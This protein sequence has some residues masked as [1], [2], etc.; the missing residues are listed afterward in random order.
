MAEVH[1]IAD[2]IF[3]ISSYNEQAKLTFNQFLIRDERPLLFHTGQR[4]IFQDTLAA[5]RSLIDPAAL[6]YISWSHWEGDETGALNDFLAAEPGAEPVHGAL[7][8]R[9]NV[10]EFAIRPAKVVDE[11]E[12]LALGTHRLRFLLTP[13]VPHAWDALMAFEET[14]GTLFVTDLFLQYGERTAL[15]ESDVVANS[16]DSFRKVPDA[17]PV[18]PR[19]VPIFERLEATAPHRLASMHG[20]A[21]SGDAV[22]ALRGLRAGMLASTD[23]GPLRES[24]L[25]IPIV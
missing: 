14:T 15:T 19:M 2:G 9:L 23:W 13:Q 21:F 16:L 3:R 24:R 22:G 8:A 7:G 1:E 20:P 17:F 11:G 4:G 18:G 12:V 6:R 5:V 10:K 25:G